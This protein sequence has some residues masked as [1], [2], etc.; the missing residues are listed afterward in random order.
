MKRLD[1]PHLLAQVASLYYEQGLTQEQV[2]R[3]LDISRSGISRLLKEARRE[4]IVEIRVRHPSPTVAS[5]ETKLRN[6]FGLQSA[7]VLAN[8]TRDADMVLRGVGALAAEQT[9]GLLR[10][11]MVLGIGWGR[12]LYEIVNAFRPVSVGHVDV[13]QIMGGIG[14]LNPHIDGAELARRLAEALGGQFHY[15]HA[16]FVVEDVA[17]C[18]ALLRQRELRRVMDMGRCAD[19]VLV[20]IGSMHP[21]VSGLVR[22]GFLT[23]SELLAIARSGAVGDICGQYIDIH[24]RIC[25]LELHRRTI[26]ID[27]LSLRKAKCVL[28]MAAWRE[29]AP[30]ILGALRGGFVDILITDDAAAQEV[31]R[32]ADSAA[33]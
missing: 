18:E 24:G 13:V 20:G 29:K 31:L 5:L 14:G 12:A 22:A 11:G 28:A 17:V 32:L 27:P 3:R 25:D 33:E 16:P 7:C 30:A 10:S 9:R 19:L 21:D 15:L 6:R 8:G 1:R 2:A 26:G 23:R 4:G